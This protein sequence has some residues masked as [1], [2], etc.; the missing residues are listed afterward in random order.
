[1]G[2]PRIEEHGIIGNL[3]TA[4]LIDCGGAINW[5][6]LPHVESSSLFARLLDAEDGGHFTVQPATPFEASHE[7]LDRT[8]VLKTQ[9]ETASGQA[10]V[11]DFMPVP[12]ITEADR[13]PQETIFRKLT[14]EDGHVDMSVEFEPRFDYARTKPTVER[15]RHGVVATS[16]EKDVF[17]SG[18]TSFS[19]SDHA[20][21][22]SVALSEGETCWLV[23]GYEQEIP[24]EPSHQQT[25]ADV[26]DYWRDWTHQCP[27]SEICSIDGPWH[28]L[29][30]RSAL[31]LK[32]LTHHE[33][34][35]ICA[36]PTTSLPEDI[37]GVRN[38][39]Y[40]FNWIRD[41][42]LTVQAFAELGHLEE[43]TQYFD[44]CLSHCSQGDPA[45]IQPLYGL[46]G[47]DDL[48]EHT[49]DH[50]SGY[51]DSTPVR[52]GN[53]AVDQQQ[54]DVYGELIQGIY[55][56]T[57]YGETLSEEDWD[58]MR[59]IINYVCGAWQEPDVGIWE[60]RGD[61]QQLVHSKIMCWVALDRGIEIAEERGFD[62]PVDH[63]IETRRDIKATVIERGYSETANS[64]VRSFGTETELDAA[65]LQIPIL[66]FLPPDDS[67]VQGTIDAIRERLA[68]D[69]A[70]VYRYEGDDGLPGEEGAFAVCSFWLVEALV[71]SGRLEEAETVFRSV[72]EYVSPLGLLAEEID[73]ESGAQLGNFPQAFSH[74]GL[75]NS[76]LQIG[77]REGISQLKQPR[78]ADNG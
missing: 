69:E 76:I 58:V 35:A 26:I 8:N 65:T 60:L 12:E 2:Y 45:D 57:R 40:R 32:L 34:G 52:I 59:D 6:C 75:I 39:D 70:L 77:N 15:A 50:L 36:A 21:H 13:I 43:V 74:I 62:A 67:R 10:T 41:S 49:L 24:I 30:V 68:T 25:L 14:C 54:L 4:A 38:W 16:D 23:L 19:I 5:C 20:A 29:A 27:E 51:R 66:G 72:S 63:W 73:P 61:P 31:A 64:F 48:E 42:T 55:A 46:H 47:H 1:M 33:T 11:T 7:Y 71:A 28:D 17:L 56:T 44:L 37:G 18:S 78:E 53:S 9:F 3:E 22:A